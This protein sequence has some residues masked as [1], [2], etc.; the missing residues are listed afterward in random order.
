[1][2]WAAGTVLNDRYIIAKEIGNGGF[3][4]TYL[5]YKRDR[6]SKV[7]I[8]TLKDAY[9]F[10]PIWHDEFKKEILSLSKCN[11]PQIVTIEDF[12]DY[13]SGWLNQ[14][15]QLYMVMEYIKGQTVFEKMRARQKQG[16]SPQFS[17]KAALFYIRQVASALVFAHD[18]HPPI[19]H[20]D[21]K[22]Q[23]IMLREDRPEAVL[24]DFGLARDVAA[25]PVSTAKLTFSSG[26]APIEQYSYKPI[27]LPATDVYGLAATLYYMLTAK[28]P[29][30]ANDRAQGEKL[31]NP[32]Q[33]NLNISEQT[34]QAIMKGLEFKLEDCPQKMQKWLDL[35][36]HHQELSPQVVTKATSEFFGSA[37]SK[38]QK[39]AEQTSP[40]IQTK[41]KA[42]TA[43]EYFDSALVKDDLGDK[44][45]TITT[46]SNTGNITGN[47]S[48]NISSDNFSVGTKNVQPDDNILQAFANDYANH[49]QNSNNQESIPP[50]ERITFRSLMN[51]VG[52]ISLLLLLCSSAAIGYLLV[53]PSGVMRLFKSDNR[54]KTSQTD[55]KSDD[56][57]KNIDSRNHPPQ[58]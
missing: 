58:S 17:E 36:T 42:K 56:L 31:I 21:L 16:K 8:K 25:N 34:C 35:L 2:A 54:P 57:A 30:D 1:M 43:S 29:T 40:Q 7:A 4:L 55:T 27:R 48:G 41:I 26:F 11:H 10:D 51:P 13:K 50:L 12:G 20:R 46:D 52:I 6:T 28:V 18:R 32:K 24:I 49:Y 44:Q 22:P 39:V 47:I 38:S 45:G 3:G 9:A 14:K 53:D 37:N 33:H 23:N 15:S 5:A 19:L